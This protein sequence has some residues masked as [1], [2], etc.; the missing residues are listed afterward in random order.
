MIINEENP[1]INMLL[2]IE[3]FNDNMYLPHIP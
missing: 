2:L 3:A 1:L